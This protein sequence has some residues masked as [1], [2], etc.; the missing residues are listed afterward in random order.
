[1]LEFV[2][3]F[4]LVSFLLLSLE[5]NNVLEKLINHLNSIFFLA[6]LSFWMPKI[7]KAQTLLILGVFGVGYVSV[8][9]TNTTPIFIITLK[10]Y[11]FF[12]LLSISIYQ[13]PC[14]VWCLCPNL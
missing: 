6:Q 9:D 8:S 12:K 10:L 5:T 2:L 7:Y 13:Y 1:M 4:L 3:S 14:R 11:N